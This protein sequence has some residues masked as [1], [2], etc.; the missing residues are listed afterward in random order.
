MVTAGWRS[1]PS[2][3]LLTY[4]CVAFTPILFKM[5]EPQ[6]IGD[7]PFDISY[8]NYDEP[9]YEQFLE[10]KRKEMEERF[11]KLLDHSGNDNSVVGIDVIRSPARNCR[12]K[13]R[14]AVRRKGDMGITAER[15]DQLVHAMWEEGR[16][17]VVVEAFPI[18]STQIYNMMPVLLSTIQS[19]LTYVCMVEGFA[20]VHYL[21]TLSGAL[22]V[23]MNYDGGNSDSFQDEA[24]GYRCS[25]RVAA[26]LL[27][28]DLL[29]RSIPTITSLSLIGRSKG[30]K[31]VVGQDFVMETL[32]LTDGRSLRYKQVEE[33]FSNPNSVVNQSA[34]GWLCGVAQQAVVGEVATPNSSPNSSDERDGAEVLAGKK[35]DL[36][37][38]YC[39]N[40][41][42]TV[43]LA[44]TLL[45][46]TSLL[47]NSQ[48]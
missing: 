44:G 8:M 42:H 12:Q 29:A 9:K 5:E 6:S 7:Y 41:N 22:L 16:P 10:V 36:L 3:S 39:G 15:D 20:S 13:C 19:S 1:Q 2:T 43:A 48:W 27:R 38:M 17:T 45:R 47:L 31:V 34:L 21:S 40:G 30:V 37:E 18:A 28:E 25:W 23:T 4:F 35:V 46:V 33:G 11:Q 26:E 32:H 24:G 14:F